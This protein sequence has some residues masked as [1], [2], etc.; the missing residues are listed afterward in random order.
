VTDILFVAGG[1]TALASVLLYAL[2]ERPLEHYPGLEEEGVQ[3]DV[4]MLPGGALFTLRG[5]L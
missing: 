1:V 5:A 4:A 2:R 3:A